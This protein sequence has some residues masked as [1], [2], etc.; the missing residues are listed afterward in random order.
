[1]IR[2]IIA[3]DA[4]DILRIYGLGLETRNASFETQVPTWNKWDQKY[5]E[6]SRFIIEENDQIVGWASLSRV[7][8]REVYKGVAEV[9]IYID[10]EFHGKS[11]GARLMKRLI[12]SS[13]ENGIWTLYSSVFPENIA[14]IKL[15]EN[16]GF[17]KLGRRDRIA[18]LDGIWRD[19]LIF[20]RRSPLVGNDQELH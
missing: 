19:T 13:E 7:S 9:S 10:P 1:M 8:E 12:E 15:H 4:A 5:L 6:H 16:F 3:E 2:N 20:E 17:R 18:K 14:T 11:L